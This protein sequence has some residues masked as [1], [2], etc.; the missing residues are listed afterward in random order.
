MSWNV[1]T[2]IP[3]LQCRRVLNPALGTV[4]FQ[5]ADGTL[6]FRTCEAEK[7]RLVFQLGTASPERAVKVAKLIEEDV[8]AIDINMGCPKDF[9]LKGGMGAALLQDPDKAASIIHAIAQSSFAKPVTCKIRLLPTLKETLSLAKK[10]EAAGAHAIGV[11][12]RLTA[13]RPREPVTPEQASMI[14]AVCSELSIPVIANGGALDIKCYDDVH[15]F[16]VP[17]PKAH[18][19]QETN[20]NP[21]VA[22][23]SC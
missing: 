23:Q 15:G 19:L 20:R 11:H 18:R 14:K 4:D 10:L 3:W 1:S 7:S 21:L 5:L 2:L 13:Q 16:K 8:S 9:S 22:H 17:Q 6:V 12:G